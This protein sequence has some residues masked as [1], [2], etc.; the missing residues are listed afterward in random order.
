MQQ[1]ST[2]SVLPLDDKSLSR[3][4]SQPTSHMVLL[5]SFCKDNP[6]HRGRD[7]TRAY[8]NNANLVLGGVDGLLAQLEV[9]VRA[10]GVGLVD[11]LGSDG[12][13][14]SAVNGDGPVR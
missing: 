6:Q 10:E 14:R 7:T 13:R 2:R 9:V 4:I 5:L 1:Q 12:G 8:M 11:R 3:Q